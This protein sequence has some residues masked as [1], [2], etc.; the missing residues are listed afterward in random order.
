MVG[1]GSSWGMATTTVNELLDGHV[2]LDVECLDRI[3]L[4]G[5]VPRLQVGGQ[6]VAFMT[7]HLGLPIPSPAVMEKIGT[8]FRRDVNAFAVAQ[9]VPIVKFGK[10]DRK[11]E[12][13]RPY[14]QRQA[15]TGV[16]GVAAIGVGQEYQN[17]FACS[18]RS[19]RGHTG[20][21]VWFTFHKADRRVT[22]FY[23]YLWDDQ[24]GPGF[25]KICAY[26]PYPIK[27]WLNGHEWAKQQARQAGIGFAEL[28][29]GFATCTDPTGLQQI[30]DRLGPADIDA[31]FDRWMSILPVPLTDADRAADYWWE[32]SMRQVET[33]RTIVFDAPRHARSFFEALVVDNLDIG[34]PDRIE[35]IFAGHP[36]RWGRPPT[37]EPTYKTRIATRDTIGV[38]VNAD[39]KHSRV[40]QYLKDGRALRIETV[41][42]DPSDLICKRRLRHLPEL[43]AKA[44][45]VNARLLDTERV[46]QGCVLASPAFERVAQS[47]LTQDGR[48]SPAL[49]FGDPRVMALLGA[50]CVGLNA[51]G[52]TNRSLRAQVS[53]LLG[54]D[55]TTN[56]MS[57]DL[58]RL[59]SKGLIQRRGTTNT[60]Q[61]TADG[62]RV[63]IFYTKVH[64]RLLRPLIAADQPPAPVELRH[65]LEVIDHHVTS[66]TDRA[67]LPNAA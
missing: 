53:Q 33:S 58:T 45:S 40:K 5:Y 19:D 12:V 52:F 42:N 25:I 13:M 51:L 62:Q 49:R 35:V 59:R 6:V 56:Q 39:Y 65:A 17:V 50:L 24:F 3:Y 9:Q 26:F 28:S 34:R 48:R 32:L 2:L 54:V 14:L 55:Y 60:Y 36:R 30:C 44:R 29:N 47:T 16:A 38:T 43:Q 4:N 61:L 15:A 63:A 27:V 46:G 37:V 21:Q 66:Y 7:R 64:D 10:L 67:R 22:C 18:Q 57:Y 1:C 23:F 8:A 41:I 20:H 31:F 11:Q